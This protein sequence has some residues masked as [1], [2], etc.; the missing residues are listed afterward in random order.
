MKSRPPIEK[1]VEAVAAHFG[2]DANTWQPGRCVDDASRAVAAYVSRRHF[3]YAAAEVAV[4]LGY[5]GHSGVHSANRNQLPCTQANGRKVSPQT[6]VMTN[7]ALTPKVPLRTCRR[8]NH[9]HSL[10]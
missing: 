1:I 8:S 3:G 6:P 10:V 7:G 4:A 9:R 2:H 5:R